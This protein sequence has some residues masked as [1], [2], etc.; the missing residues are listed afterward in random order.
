MSEELDITADDI[1]KLILNALG[2]NVGELEDI[3]DEEYD[4]YDDEYEDYDEC[5][6]SYCETENEPKVVRMPGLETYYVAVVLDDSIEEGKVIDNPIVATWGEYKG[7]IA[8]AMSIEELEEKFG[9]IISAIRGS[10]YTVEYRT[11][12]HE[13]VLDM[14][15]K[16]GRY[17]PS[18]MKAQEAYQELNRNFSIYNPNKEIDKEAILENLENLQDAIK[19]LDNNDNYHA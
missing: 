14:I 4:E 5:Y 19:N 13:A 18:V 7:K 10:G 3:E 2:F 1:T 15:E 9:D 8:M 12:T 17:I 11:P 16:G 6:C